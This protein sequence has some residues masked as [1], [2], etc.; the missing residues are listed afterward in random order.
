MLRRSSAL[1]A[2]LPILVAGCGGSGGTGSN[3]SG[4]IGRIRPLVTIAWPA[5]TREFAAPGFATA[6]RIAFVDAGPDGFDTSETFVRPEG[7]AA[8]DQTV[9]LEYPIKPG[10]H[11]LRVEFL[12]QASIST[13]LATANVEVKVLND[14]V[15]RSLDGKPLGT[16]AFS[17][18][19]TGLSLAANGELEVGGMTAIV[20]TAHTANGVAALTPGVVS[21]AATSGA[22][23]IA[24]NPDGTVTGVAE[25]TATLVPSIDGMTGTPTPIK[26][27]L[28]P[29]QAEVVSLQ[30]NDLLFDSSRNLLWIAAP[31]GAVQSLDPSTGAVGTTFQVGSNPNV[32]ALSDDGST[33]YAGL[34]TT[35]MVQKIDLTTNT[36]GQQFAALTNGSGVAG[37]ATA[38]AVQPGHPSTL[39]LAAEGFIPVFGYG[40]SIFDDGVKRPNGLGFLEGRALAWTATDRLVAWDDLSSDDTLRSVSVNAPGATTT[41]SADTG[42]NSFE[43]DFV[44]SNGRLYD[45]SGVVFDA[46]TLQRVGAFNLNI[47][48]PRDADLGPA[49]DPV[50]KRAYFVKLFN[51]TPRLYSFDLET[52]ALVGARRIAGPIYRNGGLEFRAN[53][54]KTS[55][56]LALRFPG[57]IVLIKDLAGL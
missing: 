21:L 14:G 31:G 40:A 35:G 50:R 32:I 30:T 23:R 25:G 49:I 47:E 24:I 46:N 45:R 20:V 27:L 52:F 57:Q 10:N 15:L 8:V 41:R 43:T 55:E 1:L 42:L 54:V 29:T 37:Y 44:F 4:G 53:M 12:S 28:A 33:L 16:V 22:E 39:A 19:I 51:Q 38:I 7:N 36:L 11:L 5:Q 26:V 56:G 6:A 18:T 34:R 3:G 2:L 17:S 13:P 9:K 48:T